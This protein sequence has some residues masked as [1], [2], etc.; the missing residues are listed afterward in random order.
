MSGERVLID[1][2]AGPLEVQVDAP[3]GA[4]T[5]ALWCHPHPLYGGTLD[6]KVVYTLAAA[7]QAAGL[8]AV[9]FNFRGVGRS[10]GEH[11]GGP[12]EIEDAAAVRAWTAARWP[13]APLVLGGFSFGAYVALCSAANLP[14][15]GLVTVALPTGYFDHRLPR[16]AMPW[17]YL[18]G[19][20]D[21]VFD[22]EEALTAAR[23]LTPPPQIVAFK[24]ASHFFHG[25]LPP[26]REA[27]G[28]WLRRLV[29][30]GDEQG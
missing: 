5:A 18:Q 26:L 21:E 2:P 3:A 25:Q 29:E 12:G 20:Q 10:G 4:R 1:G 9:R 16:P 24:E 8:A 14:P 19:L 22:A 7:A 27:V 11:T 13:A 30:A 6:N 23:A 28:L 17:L 15:Q